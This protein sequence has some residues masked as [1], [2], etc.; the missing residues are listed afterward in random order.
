LAELAELSA[1]YISQIERGRMRLGMYGF[2][3]IVEALD[4]LL[5]LLFN[6]IRHSASRKDGEQRLAE[7]ITC[8]SDAEFAIISEAVLKLKCLLRKHRL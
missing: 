6:D 3:K 8:C 2:E 7:E 5:S 4:I 1:G